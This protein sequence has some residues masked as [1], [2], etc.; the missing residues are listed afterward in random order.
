MSGRIDE[1]AES[2]D[3]VGNGTQWGGVE[4]VP[5]F[6]M[7]AA[8]SDELGRVKLT[9]MLGDGLLRHWKRSGQFLDGPLRGHEQIEDGAPRGIGDSA[10]DV[11]RICGY[12]TSDRLCILD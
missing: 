12:H 1:A 9:Q 2:A 7:H 3:P 11:V 4:S 5:V 10:E 6:A 8:R